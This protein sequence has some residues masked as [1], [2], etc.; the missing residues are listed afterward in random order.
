MKDKDGFIVNNEEY[1]WPSNLVA[2]KAYEWS[3]SH[4]KR[5]AYTD[6]LRGWD[7]IRRFVEFHHPLGFEAFVKKVKEE[8]AERRKENKKPIS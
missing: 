3:R 6:D 5:H 4:K 2:G 7:S 8:E 1:S